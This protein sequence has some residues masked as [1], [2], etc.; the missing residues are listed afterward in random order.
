MEHLRFT[1]FVL[2]NYTAVDSADAQLST[3][4]QKTMA[5]AGKHALKMLFQNFDTTC[6]CLCGDAGPLTGEHKIK[7]SALRSEFGE[8]ELY[9]SKTGNTSSRPNLAQSTKSKHLKFKV[10]MCESCNT[11]RTQPADREFDNFNKLAQKAICSGVDPIKLFELPKYAR[12]SEPYLNIFRYFAKLLCC[13]MAEVQAPRPIRLSEFAIGNADTNYVWLAVKKDW[14]Y[15]QKKSHLGEHQ[16]AAH[17]GLIVIGDK[18]SGSAKGFHST[19]TIGPVQY[20]FHMD[21]AE[22]E[23]QELEASYPE[24]SNWCRS[25]VVHATQFPLS[26]E[27]KLSQGLSE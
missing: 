25:R 14:T 7:A 10:R 22:I 15:G 27:E 11:N 20:V 8:T 9:I 19:L 24:F 21:L 2:R 16:F 3:H 12:G 23:T 1:L 26:R 13:H 17:G 5:F 18:I 4:H 6:C